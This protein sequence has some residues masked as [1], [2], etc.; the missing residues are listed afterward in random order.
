MDIGNF[1]EGTEKLLKIWFGY[2]D[3]HET[4]KTGDLRKIP[5]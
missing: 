3:V 5:R 1:F 2:Q 4:W